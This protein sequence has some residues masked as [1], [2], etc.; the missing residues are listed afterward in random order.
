MHFNCWKYE[1]KI[2]TSYVL[3]CYHHL[4]PMVDCWRYNFTKTKIL[5]DFYQNQIFPTKIYYW[6]FLTKMLLIFMYQ[7]YIYYWFR[8]NYFRIDFLGIGLTAYPTIFLFYF[9]N[10]FKVLYLWGLYKGNIFY[11]KIN[12]FLPYFCTYK[13]CVVFFVCFEYSVF[14]MQD[15]LP[16]ICFRFVFI[17]SLWGYLIIFWQAFCV[18]VFWLYKENKK[19]FFFVLLFKSFQNLIVH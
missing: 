16:W 5:F 18:W 8:L 7:N 4:H 1:K 10:V 14:Y 17:E 6:I 9:L 3:K 11:N 15:L 13:F 12:F 2:L 19:V